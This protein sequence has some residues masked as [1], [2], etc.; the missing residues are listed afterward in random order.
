MSTD[1]APVQAPTPSAPSSSSSSS[2]APQ[3][4]PDDTVFRAAFGEISA[5]VAQGQYSD[6]VS[7]AERAD[8][9]GDA[10]SPARLLAVA[11]MVLAYLIV[12]DL[13]P[14]RFA[15]FR[16]PDSLHNLPL[17]QGLNSLVALTWQRRYEHVYKCAESLLAVAN[18]FEEPIAQVLHALVRQFVDSFRERTFRLLSRAYTE[19]PLGL[20]EMYLGMPGAQIVPAAQSRGW[21]YDEANKIFKPVKPTTAVAAGHK[22]DISSLNTFHFVASSVGKLELD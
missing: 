13:P 22:S 20:V 16:L 17:V 21:A 9:M 3:R 10:H 1:P 6:V 2:K 11:P 14:A 4:A 12:D 5:T 18:D 7:L 15:M 8:L 19:V